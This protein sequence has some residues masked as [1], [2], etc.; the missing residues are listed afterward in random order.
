MPFIGPS[1][2]KSSFAIGTWN[3]LTDAWTQVLDLNDGTT[4]AIMNKGLS[5]PQPDK[6]IIES[7]NLRTAGVVVPRWQ[8]K[9]RHITV[10]VWLRNT[11]STTALLANIRALLNAIEN[12]PYCIRIALPGAGQYS[13]ADVL[14]VKHDIPADPQTIL[15][16]AIT[17]I[18][19]DFEC[20][21][22]LRGDRIT[23]QNLVPN[24][25]FEQPSGTGV[26]V[27]NDT[28]AT[29]N[30]YALQTG[31]APTVG[32]NVMTMFT[33]SRVAFGSPAWGPINYWQIRWRWATGLTA[34]FYLHYTDANNSLY[35]SVTG[36]S[37]S[38]I[39]RVAGVNTT[40]AT[41][42]VS[43][44]N[45]T[46]YWLQITQ[47]PGAAN[48]PP[49]LNVYLFADSAGAPGSVLATLSGPA[50]D[51]VTALIGRPQLE[52][53]GNN[54]QVGGPFAN[55]NNVSLFGP[56]GWTFSPAAGSSAVSGAWEQNTANTFTT[57]TNVNAPLASY[58]A[59]RL[60]APPAGTWDTSWIVYG[61][62]SPTGTW[63]I[64]APTSQLYGASVWVMSSGLS[65]NAVIQLTIAEY[66]ASGTFL[67]SGTFGQKNG[68]QANWT[69]ISGTYTTG[70]PNCAYVNIGLRVADTTVAGESANATVWADNIQLWNQTTTGLTV[71]PW[72]ALRSVRSPASLVVTGLVGD[73]PAPA[74]ISIGAYCASWPSGGSITLYAGR[75]LATSPA[76]Q[77][78]A[79]SFGAYPTSYTPTST[80][81]LDV[82]SWGGYYISA[83]LGSGVGW[84]PRFLS[85]KGSDM[86][87]VYHLLAR[88]R[89]AQSSGNL[90]NVSLRVVNVQQTDPGLNLLAGTDIVGQWFGPYVY[91]F[92]AANT[93]QV[94]DAGQCNMP[95]FPTGAMTDPSKLYLV[96]RAQWLDTSGSNAVDNTDWQ[97]LLPIDGS[98][99]MATINNPSNSFGAVTSQ[100]LWT[101]V[102][103]LLLN[104]GASG[105]SAAW[106]TSIE[107]SATP[108]P[109][110][111]AGGVGNQSS[112]AINVNSAADPFLT[113]DPTQ[114]GANGVTGVNQIVAV[115]A[116]Q[117]GSVYPVFTEISYSPLYLYPR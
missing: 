56:G 16:G 19:I 99:L 86:P 18:H 84:N 114:D 27:F 2:T 42:T 9:A 52:A 5:L 22:G 62:G 107:A 46:F 105:D 17:K 82:G 61:G 110:N 40:V 78:V 83:T 26:T 117:A 38:I 112:G 6:S 8:Y 53:V 74:Q 20:R 57:L 10:Q 48:D 76:A 94:V 116:D 92:T 44:A 35:V 1:P 34:N 54:L 23:L 73:L 79:S 72:C 101:Y 39:H 70:D 102:D 90:P 96:P 111:G 89:T 49:Y 75:K 64:P 31:S 29:G 68:N 51:A 7:G 95:P 103:G 11:S 80:A 50:H 32:S 33:G 71:M 14:A 81:L 98:L 65:A 55:V 67:R 108:N 66:N 21:V 60:D 43:L 113:L 104:R 58:G 106:T 63:A 69:Q 115:L 85:P 91:P 24:P 88:V 45:V 41:A 25:G 59:L 36:T 4:F 12:P 93:W 30:A 87:G 47:F 15:A 3:P 28:F 100:W 97:A 77:F 109:A 37:A 13:Y